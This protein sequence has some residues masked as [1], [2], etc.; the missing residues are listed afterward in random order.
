MLTLL[1]VLSLVWI[2]VLIQ[3]QYH[4]YLTQSANG[5]FRVKMLVLSSVSN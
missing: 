2:S 1:D 3:V 5:T 4:A